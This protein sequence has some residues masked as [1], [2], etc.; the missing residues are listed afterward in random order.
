MSLYD[1]KKKKLV[2]AVQPNV[3]FEGTSAYLSNRIGKHSSK[4]LHTNTHT[5]V[6]ARVCAHSD[7][8]TSTSPNSAPDPSGAAPPIIPLQ[9]SLLRK[10]YPTLAALPHVACSNLHHT[11]CNPSFAAEHK[12]S[13]KMPQYSTLGRASFALREPPSSG[14]RRCQS[15]ETRRGEDE[16]KERGREGSGGREV[17]RLTGGLYA[18]VYVHACV[19]ACVAEEGGL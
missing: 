19:R 15:V 14:E 7:A 6:R 8:P 10:E 5:H 11:D 18:H 12:Q 1:V 17:E 2:L 16:I 9:Q 4:V 13:K 3:R